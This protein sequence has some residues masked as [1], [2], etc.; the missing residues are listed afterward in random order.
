MASRR[1]MLAESVPFTT[2]TV[3]PTVRISET[4]V[5]TVAFPID[6]P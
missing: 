4:I 6:M 5:I 3:D 2:S 1:V